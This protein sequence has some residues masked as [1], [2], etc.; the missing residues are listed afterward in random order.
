LHQRP[1]PRT[2]QKIDGSQVQDDMG[3]SFAHVLAQH[4][5]ENRLR[6]S[7]QLTRQVKNLVVFGHLMG[8]PQTYGQ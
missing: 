8:A 4:L 3:W 6:K 1:N 5:T 2:V 7:I